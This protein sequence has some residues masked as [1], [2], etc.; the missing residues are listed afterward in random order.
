MFLGPGSWQAQGLG[1][2]VGIVLRSVIG[3]AECSDRAPDELSRLA[4]FIRAG[5]DV[6]DKFA[7]LA[8]AKL[9][10]HHDSKQC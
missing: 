3:V 10:L 2:N 1:P 7:G 9:Q 4:D 6:A 8:A 5:D